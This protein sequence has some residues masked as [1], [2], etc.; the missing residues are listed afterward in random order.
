MQWEL[1]TGRR[2]TIHVHTSVVEQIYVF[3]LDGDYDGYSGSGHGWKTYSDDGSKHGDES[4]HGDFSG[5]SEDGWY[6]YSKNTIWSDSD[7]EDFGS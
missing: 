1:S 7:D 3:F 5:S 4:R 2:E 6:T